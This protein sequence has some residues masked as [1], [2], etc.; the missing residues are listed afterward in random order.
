MAAVAV[1]VRV[2]GRPRVGVA[3]VLHRVADVTR[4]RPAGAV[5]AALLD[6]AAQLF[7]RGD[8]VV[9]LDGCR[10]GDRV[11]VHPADAG[12]CAEASLDD[13]LL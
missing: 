5:V 3:V 7:E 2:R 8:R 10:L 12:A 6:P 9:E 4:H 1:P 13:L 11:R